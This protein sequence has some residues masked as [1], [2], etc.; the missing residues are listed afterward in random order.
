MKRNSSALVLAD[1]P[2]GD[3]ATI[4]TGGVG[5]SCSPTAGEMAVIDVGLLIQ[6][7]LLSTFPK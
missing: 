5:K 2:K 6:K 7:F 3:V 1:D 4:S